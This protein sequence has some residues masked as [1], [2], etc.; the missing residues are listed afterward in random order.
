MAE[1]KRTRGTGRG[2]DESLSFEEIEREILDI[3]PERRPRGATADLDGDDDPLLDDLDDEGDGGARR[4]L[5]L[6]ALIGL[7]LIA[8][9]GWYLYTQMTAP[10]PTD[11]VPLIQAED[12]PYKARPADP[13]GMEVPNQDKLVYERVE[14]G[15]EGE[16]AA[17][18]LLPPPETPRPPPAP[19]VAEEAESAAPE[20]DPEVSVAVPATTEAAQAAGAPASEAVASGVAQPAPAAEAPAQPEPASQP[21]PAPAAPPQAAS[22]VAATPPAEGGF[23]VQ[24][25]SVREEVRTETEWARLKKAHADLL[26]P[27][28]PVVERADLGDKGVWYRLRMGHFSTRAAASALC[29]ELKSRKVDCLVVANN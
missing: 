20:A 24:L 4:G 21:E 3:V 11:T 28:T 8:A 13:G 16:G 14:G 22:Q 19:E 18:Q 17:E 26:T 27:F 1:D 2:G 7:V 15:A 6:G 10:P 12:V 5:L 29:D 25:A 9:G 23:L